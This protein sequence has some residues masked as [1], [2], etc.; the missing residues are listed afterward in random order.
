MEKVR[1]PAHALNWYTAA[2]KA[3]VPLKHVNP[4]CFVARVE[5]DPLKSRKGA[6]DALREAG[7]VYRLTR[8]HAPDRQTCKRSL[9]GHDEGWVCRLRKGHDVRGERELAETRAARGEDGQ[10]SG[11]CARPR[12]EVRGEVKGAD[13]ARPQGEF[14]DFGPP[15]GDGRQVR[16]A[17]VWRD[18]H[19]E[20]EAA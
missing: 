7:R 17:Q 8:A 11:R 14:L 3:E 2:I 13:G 4:R 19:V 12:R 18:G 10:A 6:V 1:Q 20:R 9:R 5:L 15:V 16:V